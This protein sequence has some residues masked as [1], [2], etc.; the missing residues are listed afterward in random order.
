[1]LAFI[2]LREQGTKVLRKKLFLYLLDY[3]YTY[4]KKRIF[5]I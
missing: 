4:T 1:M 2:S 5:V 3:T